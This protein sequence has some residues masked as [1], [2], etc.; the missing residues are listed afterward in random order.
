MIIVRILGG[1][2]EDKKLIKKGGG[3]EIHFQDKTN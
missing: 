3:L 1:R 2:N